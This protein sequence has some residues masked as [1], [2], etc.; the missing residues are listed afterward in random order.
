MRRRRAVRRERSPSGGGRGGLCAA[1][2][3]H[4]DGART[5]HPRQWKCGPGLWRRGVLHCRTGAFP[6]GEDVAPRS[7]AFRGYREAARR[8]RAA[9][10]PASHERRF[11][12]LVDE[13]MTQANAQEP[14]TPNLRLIEGQHNEP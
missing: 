9:L 7:P 4:D 6:H 10:D 11:A 14:H 1:Q 13:A 8:M 12:A 2:P 3:D 5:A